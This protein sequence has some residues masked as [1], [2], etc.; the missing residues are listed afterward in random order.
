MLGNMHHY[1]YLYKLL[2]SLY[3]NDK[4]RSLLIHLYE[5]LSKSSWTQI[6]AGSINHITQYTPLRNSMVSFSMVSH[7]TEVR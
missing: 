7:S 4:D 3:L 1:Y 6:F 5:V 2:L